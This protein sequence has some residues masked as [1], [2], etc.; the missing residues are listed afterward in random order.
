MSIVAVR[1]RSF[2]IAA[3]RATQNGLAACKT[4]ASKQKAARAIAMVTI[5][6]KIKRYEVEPLCLELNNTTVA[7]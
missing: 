6:V 7:L 1:N 2:R 3:A 4:L 5:C